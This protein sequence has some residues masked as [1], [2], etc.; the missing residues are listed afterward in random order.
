M[1]LK[2]LGKL[3]KYDY[4]KIKSKDSILI[5]RRGGTFLPT[6]G[7]VRVKHTTSATLLMKYNYCN[8]RH[9]CAC[10][11]TVTVDI[12]VHVELL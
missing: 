6:P 3:T 2:H 10:R 1:C 9:T 8:S 12:H 5:I 4:Y 7:H 11:T